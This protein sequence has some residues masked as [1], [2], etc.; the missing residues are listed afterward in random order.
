M[1]ILKKQYTYLCNA[2]E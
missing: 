1:T 2:C